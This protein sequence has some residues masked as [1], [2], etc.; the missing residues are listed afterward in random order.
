MSRIQPQSLA[1]LA[2]WSIQEPRRPVPRRRLRR[3]VRDAI[4]RVR[5]ARTQDASTTPA[6]DSSRI[7]VQA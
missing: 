7:P 3:V 2:T 4:D 5:R 6:P 1:M